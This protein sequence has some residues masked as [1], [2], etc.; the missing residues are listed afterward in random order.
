MSDRDF[1]VGLTTKTYDDLSPDFLYRIAVSY[2]VTPGTWTRVKVPV[3]AHMFLNLFLFISTDFKSLAISSKDYT[4]TMGDL[5]MRYNDID[6]ARKALV[7]LETLYL[8]TVL[9]SKN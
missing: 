3:Q 7:P 1:F 5:E 9:G 8:N 6:L 2:E 4:V